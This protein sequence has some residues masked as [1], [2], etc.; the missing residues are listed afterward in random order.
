MKDILSVDS[1]PEEVGLDGRFIL[2]EEKQ[3]PLSEG[4]SSFISE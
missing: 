1:L 4:P 3:F 2:G